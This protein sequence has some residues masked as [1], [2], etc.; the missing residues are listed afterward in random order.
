MMAKKI[1]IRLMA[2]SAALGDVP[3]LTTFASEIDEIAGHLP[4][5]PELSRDQL[6]ELKESLVRVAEIIGRLRHAAANALQTLGMGFDHA[7]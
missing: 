5:S 6:L 7:G 3:G 1:G 4:N 2:L